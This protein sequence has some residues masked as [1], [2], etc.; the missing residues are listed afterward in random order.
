MNNISP[1]GYTILSENI[2]FLFYN[3]YEMH[4]LNF[5]GAVP[6]HVYMPFGVK[7]AASLLMTE[8][9]LFVL[10]TNGT[11]LQKKSSHTIQCVPEN[12]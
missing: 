6:P 4:R 12:K 3:I 10:L 7:A 9:G 8:L 2:T 5:A 1:H 11:F